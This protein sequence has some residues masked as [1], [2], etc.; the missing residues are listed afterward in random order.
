MLTS[1]SFGDFQSRHL[2]LLFDKFIFP[3]N[4]G[5]AT[6]FGYGKRHRGSSTFRQYSLSQSMENAASSLL[7]GTS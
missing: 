6:E 5:H 1:F 7:R 2:D 3:P 4:C